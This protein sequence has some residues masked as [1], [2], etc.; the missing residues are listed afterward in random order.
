MEGGSNRNTPC[1]GENITY[2]CTVPALSHAW[3]VPQYGVSATISVQTTS[4]TNEEPEFTMRL[5][6]R[7]STAITSSLSV[8]VFTSLNGT[9][10]TCTD[11]ITLNGESQEILM[12]I[13]GKLCASSYA[14]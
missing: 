14:I 12:E 5:L 1:I 4:F 2:I 6:T 10:I 3:N 13:L 11:S 8:I 9:R 7:S